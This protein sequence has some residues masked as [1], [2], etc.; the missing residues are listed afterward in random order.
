MNDLRKLPPVVDAPFATRLPGDSNDSERISRSCSA[1]A[2]QPS[3]AFICRKVRVW[4]Y[5]N[6]KKYA[7]L[8]KDMYKSLDDSRIYEERTRRLP[9]REFF[10]KQWLVIIGMGSEVPG[11]SEET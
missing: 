9:A 1:Q 7:N 3:R 4:D 10:R 11:L 8:E 6:E 5:F 2:P